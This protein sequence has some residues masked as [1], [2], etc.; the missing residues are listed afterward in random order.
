[1]SIKELLFAVADIWMI[2]VGFTYGIK[3][4]R[5]YRNYL[6]GLEWI[7][8][9]TSGTNFLIYGLLKAGHDSPM[10]AFAFFLDAFSRSVGITLILVL[11]LMKVTHRYKPSVA[12][13]VGA[14]AL[15]G[16]VGFVLSVYAEEIGTP[17]K[18]FYIVANVLTTLF[19]IYFSKRLWEIGERGHAVWAGI[20]TA[21][22]FVIAATYDFVHIPGDDAEHTIFYIFALSTW[23]LQM[24]TYYRAYRAFDAYNKKVDAPAV[25][26]DAPVTA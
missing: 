25:T 20:A 23:G 18:I 19:L 17:G 1:M 10:Y 7:I 3:F 4:I 16:V 5:S 12:V 24:F 2:A 15:A 14:F 13:D 22:G 21:C 11:G 26:G 6:L 8:V 9:A